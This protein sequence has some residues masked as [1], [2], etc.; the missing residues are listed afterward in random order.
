MRNKRSEFSA[1]TKLAAIVRA[2]WQCERI[3][4]G[5][6]CPSG[7]NLHYDHIIPCGIGGTNDLDNCAVL[8]DIHHREKTSKLDIPRIA[9]TKRQARNHST[10]R[11]K[12]RNPIPGS[13]DTKW[14]RKLS[15][16]TV[17]RD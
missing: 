11:P 15:G 9:K 14:K 3:D 8:C 17:L 6:R 5:V 1:K 7:D 2:D 4:G 16:K 12:S 13:R 10:G